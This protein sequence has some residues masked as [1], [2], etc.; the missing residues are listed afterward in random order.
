MKNTFPVSRL[1]STLGVLLAA[2]LLGAGPAPLRAQSPS[3]SIST[4]NG[5]VVA[6]IHNS[7]S[8]YNL[9]SNYS[10]TGAY[11]SAQATR[12]FTGQDGS[13]NTRTMTFTGSAS[14]SATYGQL[15][16]FARGQVTNTYYNANNPLFYDGNTGTVN[17]AGSPD[18]LG[19]V[20]FASF[21]D[22]LQF[23][24]Q[25]QAGYSARYFFHVD[26]TNSGTNALEYLSVNIAGNGETFYNFNPGTI[27]TIYATKAYLINGTTPQAISVTFSSQFSLSTDSVA[28]GSNVS[29]MANF[30]NTAS[31]AGIQIVDSNGRPVSGVT[32]TAASGTAYPMGVPEPGTWALLAIG[33]GLLLLVT[34]R[35]VVS[36]CPLS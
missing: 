32:Y 1:R 9:D 23:G 3:S 13:G 16:L 4:S 11:T 10:G 12:A 29:G 14:S 31:L 22:T 5:V 15:H 19:A 25:L 27:D 30:S 18:L 7:P 36:E 33:M 28:D 2:A 21:T 6:N 20:A 34:R 24:G 35:R 26:G 8:D 17:P